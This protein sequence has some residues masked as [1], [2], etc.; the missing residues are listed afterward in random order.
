MK[1]K[2]YNMIGENRG[3]NKL[4]DIIDDKKVYLNV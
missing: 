4:V 1:N 3:I 2:F